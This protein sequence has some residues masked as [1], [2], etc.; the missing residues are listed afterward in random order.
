ME[1]TLWWCIHSNAPQWGRPRVPLV[2]NA[3]N[4]VIRLWPLISFLL[5]SSL[6]IPIMCYVQ[7]ALL[8]SALLLVGCQ[9]PSWSMVLQSFM[10]GPY[11]SLTLQACQGSSPDGLNNNCYLLQA[12]VSCASPLTIIDP[13]LRDWWQP[14]LHSYQDSASCGGSGCCDLSH[15]V[16]KPMALAVE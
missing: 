9:Q 2:K 10:W 16:T 3:R 12:Q 15:V 7:Y 5:K 13:V 14:K 11:L 6:D 1:I 8:S 4:W